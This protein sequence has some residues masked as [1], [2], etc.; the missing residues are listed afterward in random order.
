MERG[1]VS[2]QDDSLTSS[3]AEDHPAVCLGAIVER[4]REI[5][6]LGGGGLER[7]HLP[8]LALAEVDI[9]AGLESKPVEGRL[10]LEAPSVD[11]RR[12]GED[13][14]LEVVSERPVVGELAVELSVARAHAT[15]RHSS[16]GTSRPDPSSISTVHASSSTLYPV[17]RPSP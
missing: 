10:E 3:V 9:A 14:P 15:S 5:G 12:H 1:A 8:E 4:N 16:I 7:D 11:R 13:G 6:A 17:T 2:F